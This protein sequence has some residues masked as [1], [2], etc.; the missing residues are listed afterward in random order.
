MLYR[1]RGE[2][3]DLL[4]LEFLRSSELLVE[5]GD[6]LVDY[7]E[8][9]ERNSFNVYRCFRALYGPE[10]AAERLRRF[11]REAEK[12]YAVQLVALR[13]RDAALAE[14]WLGQGQKARRHICGS[15]AGGATWE[16]PVA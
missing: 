15:E 3:P 16:I 6:D 11:I 12:S 14:R 4:H 9:V 2:E 10:E 7:Y 13:S 5:I 8:D 1:L